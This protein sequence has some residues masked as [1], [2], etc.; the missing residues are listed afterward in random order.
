[1]ELQAEESKNR[2]R[3]NLEPRGESTGSSAKKSKAARSLASLIYEDT[4][5]E[6]QNLEEL[7]TTED[8]D[9]S[10]QE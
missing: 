8:L 4:S 6:E 7:E 1:M 2:K 5:D 3:V 9:H 10:R